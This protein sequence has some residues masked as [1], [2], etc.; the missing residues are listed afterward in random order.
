MSDQ[1]EWI[2]HFVRSFSSL[3]LIICY[4]RLSNA[5]HELYLTVEDKNKDEINVIY[6]SWILIYKSN[7][8]TQTKN[9]KKNHCTTNKLSGH[10][11]QNK[12]YQTLSEL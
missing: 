12:V 11:I 3:Q 9:E 2:F 1:N 4:H 6:I 5:Y 7:T 10:W 8:K